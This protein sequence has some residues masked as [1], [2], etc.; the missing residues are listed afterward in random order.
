M[1]DSGDVFSRLRRL[2]IQPS[3]DPVWLMAE[4]DA[5]RAWVEYPRLCAIG[6]IFGAAE[7]VE[8]QRWRVI[9]HHST[10]PQQARDGLAHYFRVL[11][12]EETDP[13]VNAEYVAAHLK[14][15]WEKVDELTA[16]GRRVRVIRIECFI[17][18]REAEQ[19]AEP[20]RP[21]D[22]D[23]L[24]PAQAEK[25]LTDG[26]VM[27]PDEPTGW[28]DAAIRTHVLSSVYPASLPDDVRADS[29]QALEDYPGG[30]LL[31]VEYTIGE[32]IEDRWEPMGHTR[33]TPSD[34]RR[35]LATR[36]RFRASNGKNLGLPIELDWD[37]L[38]L[39][40]LDEPT[41]KAYL[42]AAKRVEADR[43]GYYVSLPGREFQ[44]IRVMR[45]VRYGV[46]GPEP[47]R[48]SD[49]DP[50]PPVEVQAL[51]NG[52]DRDDDE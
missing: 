12:S 48:P 42:R 11:A 9:D 1:T 8:G 29:A 23:P 44:V 14:F 40:E 25:D 4:D 46:D 30:V 39:P 3:D 10:S 2:S 26:F 27:D 32:K 36:L 13:D 33:P 49:P 5:R 6:P 20:P 51:E 28:G 15:E 34:A 35:H 21:A 45:I 50:D 41:Q 24:D 37:A 31:P 22:L 47:P 19:E 17:R 18:A 52:Y 7:Q 38:G 16:G 43:Q